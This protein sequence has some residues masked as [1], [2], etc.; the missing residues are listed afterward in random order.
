MASLI[1]EVHLIICMDTRVPIGATLH[2]LDILRAQDWQKEIVLL[3]DKSWQDYITVEQ[4][5]IFLDRKQFFHE[6]SMSKDSIVNTQALENFLHQLDDFEIKHVIQLGELSWGRWITAYLS[7]IKPLDYQEI[8]FSNKKV[9]AVEVINRIS[10]E[11]GIDITNH[12]KEIPR[13]A[14]VYID[15]YKNDELSKDLMNILAEGIGQVPSWVNIISKESDQ[16]YFNQMGLE[17]NTIDPEETSI[18]LFNQFVLCFDEN[19]KFAQASRSYN[20]A[21]YGCEEENSS[22]SAFLPG[23]ILI[24]SDEVVHFSEL[25][26]VLS[27]WKRGR[28]KEL[29]FQWVNMNIDIDVIESFHHRV[30]RRKLQSYASDLL[31]CQTILDKF[32]TSVGSISERDIKDFV[33]RMRGNVSNDLYSL[34]FSLKIL[35]MITERMLASAACGERL[36]QRLGSDYHRVVI[37]EALVE[38][39]VKNS[40]VPFE[41]IDLKKKIKDFQNFL[42]KVDYF[43]D[44]SDADIHEKES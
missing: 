41:Q 8:K 18:N 13:N 15:P 22:S 2:A 19:S 32:N 23:D 7:D 26:N 31:R 39:I 17:D 20:V 10:D 27:Y 37:G 43:N 16:H 11:L 3:C 29:A 25:Y 12:Q 14:L 33:W 1:P 9:T 38:G 5:A 34:S 4:P 30:E 40:Q 44:H 28:L 6:T 36:F 24:Q 42:H 35:L 21:L